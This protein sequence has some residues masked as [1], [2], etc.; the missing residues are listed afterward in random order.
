MCIYAYAYVCLYMYV[1]TDQYR[2]GIKFIIFCIVVANR[3]ILKTA[4]QE[5]KYPI[6]KE[7]A[8]KK[9]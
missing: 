9:L 3:D 4:W 5:E 6:Q 1:Y 7:D 8:D 2:F